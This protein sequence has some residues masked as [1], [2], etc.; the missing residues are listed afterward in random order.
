[1]N[2]LTPAQRRAQLESLVIE[3]NTGL[4]DDEEATRRLDA[5]G[6]TE[7]ELEGVAC[8]QHTEVELT[9]K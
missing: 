1:M 8:C 3:I 5:I 6:A 2:A 4:V 9:K 7:D